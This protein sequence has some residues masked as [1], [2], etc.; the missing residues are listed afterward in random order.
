METYR[1]VHDVKTL[2]ELYSKMNTEFGSK[3]AKILYISVL[4]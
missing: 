1:T 3:I 4:D 2:K